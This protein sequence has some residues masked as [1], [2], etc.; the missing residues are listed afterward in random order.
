MKMVNVKNLKEWLIN[1]ND[2]DFIG[3]DDG[4]LSLQI[5][6]KEAYY[7]IGGLPNELGEERE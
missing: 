5:F 4:G 3:I 7:E 1:V 6:G 2:S